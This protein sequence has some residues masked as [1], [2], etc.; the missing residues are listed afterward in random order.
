MA[1]DGYFFILND[2]YEPQSKLWDIINVPLSFARGIISNILWL[3]DNSAKKL[4]HALLLK[5]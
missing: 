2:G 5:F 4:Q 1:L 3:L